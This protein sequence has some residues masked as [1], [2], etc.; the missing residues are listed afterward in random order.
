MREVVGF[1][2]SGH[3]CTYF[4]KYNFRCLGFVCEYS[5]KAAKEQL[6]SNDMPGIDLYTFV[7]GYKHDSLHCMYV[8]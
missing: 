2:K 4:R 3:I 6:L 5:E 7:H 8:C 1:R